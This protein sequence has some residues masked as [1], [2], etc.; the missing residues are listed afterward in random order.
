MS[1]AR[2]L[3][4]LCVLFQKLIFYCPLCDFKYKYCVEMVYLSTNSII[5]SYVYTINC[6]V[7]WVHEGD[8]TVIVF[9]KGRATYHVMSCSDNRKQFLYIFKVTSLISLLQILFSDLNA[10]ISIALSCKYQ[11]ECSA[12]FGIYL[13]LSPWFFLFQKV[14][15]KLKG[16]FMILKYSEILFI[17]LK[18]VQSALLLHVRVVSDRR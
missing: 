17:S 8:S 5:L 3:D 1:H 15:V 14:S 11:N 16:L 9:L 10:N 6:I 7:P 4:S 18:P 12:A 13:L 2:I